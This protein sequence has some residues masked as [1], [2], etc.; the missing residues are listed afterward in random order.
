MIPD[1]Q[2]WVVAIVNGFTDFVSGLASTW[3]SIQIIAESIGKVFGTLFSGIFGDLNADSL[4]DKVN[5]IMEGIAGTVYESVPKIQ[6]GINSVID[7]FKQLVTDLAPTWQNLQDIAIGLIDTFK[8]LSSGIGSSFSSTLVSII[9]GVVNGITGTLAKL[10]QFAQ[11]NT[12]LIKA[13]T[14]IGVFVLGLGKLGASSALVGPLLLGL[15]TS[16]AGFVASVSS[17]LSLLLGP[18]GLVIAG[19]VMFVKAWQN[20]WGNVREITASVWDG[21]KGIFETGVQIFNGFINN[22]GPTWDNIK[23]IFDSLGRIISGAIK[24]IFPSF[25]SLSDAFSKGSQSINKFAKEI[26][27]SQLG[28]SIADVF[29]KVSGVIADF[30][31]SLAENGLTD[32]I[33]DYFK[34]DLSGLSSVWNFLKSTFDAGIGVF[35]EFVDNLGPVWD[36]LSASWVVLKDIFGQLKTAIGDNLK[37]VIDAVMP[38]LSGFL[39]SLGGTKM[40]DASGWGTILAGVLEYLSGKIRDFL[41]YIKDHPQIIQFA[42]DI[43]TMGIM[44]AA[45]LPGV[46]VAIYNFAVGVYNWLTNAV[47]TVQNTYTEWKLK[48]DNIYLTISTAVTNIVTTLQ[49]WY[50]SLVEKYNQVKQTLM[51]MYNEWKNKWDSFVSYVSSAK[52][53]ILQKIEDIKKGIK[54]KWDQIKKDISDKI[55]EIKKKVDEKWETFKKAGKDL[56]QKLIDGI[57]EKGTEIATAVKSFIEDPFGKSK[58]SA[59]ANAKSTGSS[60]GGKAV[61]GINSQKG[62]AQSAGSG[63]GSSAISAISGLTSSAYSSGSSIGQSIANG[64]NSMRNTVA[65]AASSLAS[66]ISSYLPHSPAEKGPLSKLPNFK[67]YLNEPLEKA[68]NDVEPIVIKGTSVLGSLKDNLTPSTVARAPTTTTNNNSSIGGD[69]IINI[70]NMNSQLDI[71]DLVNKIDRIQKQRGMQGGFF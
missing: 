2:N 63:L 45:A 60:V 20:N 4:S 65:S 14:A 44:V 48:W 36:N 40:G 18:L 1:I 35:N 5:A 68:V 21:L 42:A 54:E 6:N 31:M 50:N 59:E 10:F 17:G 9:A 56:I 71:N 67:A 27:N 33:K 51:T 22:L 49:T 23:I 43:V 8:S 57:K 32:T 19:V 38:S 47:T 37:T 64:L 46:V 11:E 61:E 15:K 52:D 29:N 16:I 70:E 13:V 26:K 66:T 69:I 55:D 58:S 39:D 41:V 25:T 34:I 7:F 24:T 30:T 3:V 28:K 62:S 12:G 53:M